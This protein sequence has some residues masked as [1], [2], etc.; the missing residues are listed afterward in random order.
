MNRRK[1]TEKEKERER[2]I[3]RDREPERAREQRGQREL[4]DSLVN[5]EPKS[6]D[7]GHLDLRDSAWLS[8]RVGD[9]K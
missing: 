2:G 7:S 5:V 9:S 4:R 1:E 6:H 3:E 8:C